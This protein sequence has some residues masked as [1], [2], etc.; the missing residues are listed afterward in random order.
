MKKI[1]IVKSSLCEVKFNPREVV[2]HQCDYSLL[3]ILRFSLLGSSYTWF[4][5]ALTVVHFKRQRVT[6]F[7]RWKLT[8]VY[9][10]YLISV[11]DIKCLLTINNVIFTFTLH[12]HCPAVTVV[13]NVYIFI[14]S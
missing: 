12:L 3:D 9:N 6:I 14:L 13:S 2:S 5:L 4:P 10:I 7:L 1:I 8:A 11:D